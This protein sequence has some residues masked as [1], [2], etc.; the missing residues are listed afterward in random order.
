MTQ[1]PATI[2]C[3]Y[4]PFSV[5]SVCLS[6]RLSNVYLLSMCLS[7][8][9]VFL[10]LSKAT[11]NFHIPILRFKLSSHSIALRVLNFTRKF[12]SC[13]FLRCLRAYFGSR[14][15]PC[16]RLPVRVPIHSQ[17]LKT[18]TVPSIIDWN[19]VCLST[20]VVFNHSCACFGKWWKT[21]FLHN[22]WLCDILKMV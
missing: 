13:K 3:R 10:S 19:L 18:E 1:F 7:L 17:S 15:S 12:R 20:M 6:V 21:C 16:I 5:F 11:N 22:S 14:V 4:A 2:H 9:P 8:T